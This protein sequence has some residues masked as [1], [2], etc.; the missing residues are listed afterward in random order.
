[1]G[2][3]LYD[4]SGDAILGFS[5]SSSSGTNYLAP[6]TTVPEPGTLEMMLAGV[7]ALV[8]WWARRKPAATPFRV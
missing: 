7:M 3:D 1:V 2:I 5:L 4:A 6:T 8:G